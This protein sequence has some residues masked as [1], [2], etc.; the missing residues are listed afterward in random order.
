MT[1]TAAQGG[2]INDALGS[3]QPVLWFLR[4]VRCWWPISLG[5]TT[6]RMA[7]HKSPQSNPIYE[8]WRRH[9]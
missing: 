4:S 3:A 9:V 8:T 7:S 6:S 5:I 1:A 2:H